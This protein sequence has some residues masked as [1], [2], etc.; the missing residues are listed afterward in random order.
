M[1]GRD[2]WRACLSAAIAFAVAVASLASAAEPRALPVRVPEGFVV[3][4]YADDDL[5][6]NITA[7]TIDHRGRV[8]V[9]GPGYIRTLRDDDGDGRADRSLP[10]AEGHATGARG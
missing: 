3:D 2:G 6:T 1:N 9:A 8:V 4:L 7:M 5:A 10:Y